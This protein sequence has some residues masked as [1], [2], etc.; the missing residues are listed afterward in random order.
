MLEKFLVK[1]E[2][3][4]ELKLATKKP[5][6]VTCEKI[7]RS[8]RTFNTSEIKT[9]LENL[10]LT[11]SE[12]KEPLPEI[13]LKSAEY[14]IKDL[15]FQMHQTGLYNRQLKLWKSLGNTT[16][17]SF[18]ELSKG[19]IKKKGLDFSIIDLCTASKNVGVCGLI[20][21]APY[22]F[23]HFKSSLSTAINISNKNNLRGIVYFLT[24]KPDAGFINNIELITNIFDKTAKYEAIL[25]GTRDIRLNVVSIE[26]NNG[27]YNFKHVFPKVE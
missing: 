15:F 10:S 27:S 26:K 8:P 18:Y 1:K 13:L 5:F 3:I 25:T 6:D 4:G 19:L 14:L 20:D 2:K 9:A 21:P 11:L 24:N 16:E 12:T 7:T 17:I 22:D 23:T